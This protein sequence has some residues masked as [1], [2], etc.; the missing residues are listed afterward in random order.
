MIALDQCYQELITNTRIAIMN[1]YLDA[2][3]F[4]VYQLLLDLIESYNVKQIQ[5]VDMFPNTYHVEN[6]CALE[7]KK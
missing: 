4:E 1:A 5:P 7:L 6:I 3:K 2:D